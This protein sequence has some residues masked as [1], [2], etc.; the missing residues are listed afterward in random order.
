MFYNYF[1]SLINVEKTPE[2]GEIGDPMTYNTRE[3]KYS[4]DGSDA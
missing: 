4:R 1:S 3:D 2:H